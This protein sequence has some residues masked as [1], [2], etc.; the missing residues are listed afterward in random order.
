[1]NKNTFIYFFQF[2]HLKINNQSTFIILNSET[3]FVFVETTVLRLLYSCFH[4][5]VSLQSSIKC[6]KSLSSATFTFPACILT[7]CWQIVTI[8]ACLSP[9]DDNHLF[10]WLVTYYRKPALNRII[11]YRTFNCY[12]RCDVISVPVTC[13][14]IIIYFLYIY[15]SVRLW[16]RLSPL[17][18]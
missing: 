10:L 6:L 4:P 18:I 1:M 13:R 14:K 12:I 8:L 9:S 16:K 7:Y 17:A 11:W 15:I 3:S 5:S 2:W